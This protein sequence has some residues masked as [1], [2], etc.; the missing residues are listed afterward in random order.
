MKAVILAGGDLPGPRPLTAGRPG[1]VIP[2]FGKPLVGLVLDLL[3][4]HGVT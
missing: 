3:R 2:V 1:S 4:R